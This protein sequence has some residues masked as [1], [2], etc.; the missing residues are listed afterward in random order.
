MKDENRVE[1]RELPRCRPEEFPNVIEQL[2][3]KIGIEPKPAR[4]KTMTKA[5]KRIKK[6]NIKMVCAEKLMGLGTSTQIICGMLGLK[7]YDIGNL[8]TRLRRGDGLFL[9]ARGR[10]PRILPNQV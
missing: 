8:R 3:K 5:A 10:V 1:S 4:V 6:Y 7:N 2:R 9:R